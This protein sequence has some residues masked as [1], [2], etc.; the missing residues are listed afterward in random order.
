MTVGAKDEASSS[1][2]IKSSKSD[3]YVKMNSFSVQ[4]FVDKKRADYILAATRP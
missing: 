2:Y 1:Y 3:Y 4:E